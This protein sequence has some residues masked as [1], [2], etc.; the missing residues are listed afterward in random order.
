MCKYAGGT[1]A[2]GK[3]RKNQDNAGRSSNNCNKQQHVSRIG[4]EEW[5][6]FKRLRLLAEAVSTV[7]CLSQLWHGAN[8]TTKS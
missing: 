3:A 4:K 6:E 8:G 5:K 7:C 1:H 2:A